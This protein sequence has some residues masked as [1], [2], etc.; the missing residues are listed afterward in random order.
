M[1]INALV[2]LLHG[3]TA[4]DAIGSWLD[5][6][7]CYFI[8]LPFP[9]NNSNQGPA[10]LPKEALVALSFNQ[11]DFIE[12]ENFPDKLP[13]W[14]NE[15]WWF[16]SFSYEAGLKVNEI[17][18]QNENN[19]NIPAV[20]CFSPD[21]VL[22]EFEKQWKVLYA[23]GSEIPDHVLHE[24]KRHFNNPLAPPVKS[25]INMLEKPDFASYKRAMSSVRHHL[26]RGDVYE[27]NYCISAQAEFSSLDAVRIFKKLA[28][29]T[30]APFSTLAKYDHLLLI[31]ASPE[32]FVKSDGEHIFLQPMKGTAKRYPENDQADDQSLKELL[33]SEKERAEN[34]MI[35][36][37]SRNDLAKLAGYGVSVTEL[38]GPRTLKNVHQMVSTIQAPVPQSFSWNRLMECLYPPG[39]MT[40]A[41]KVSAMK[42]INVLESFYRGFFSGITGYA[43]PG[44]KFDF[45][46]VIRSI[47]A[48]TRNRKMIIPAG[49]AIT[50]L[51]SDELEFRECMLKLEAMLLALYDHEN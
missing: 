47:I 37:L 46:V 20:A 6:M 44:G 35:V 50:L 3:K 38:F 29:R 13:Q 19:L 1:S 49:S 14:D 17:T 24:I 33:S 8:R 48:N 43:C 36:D 30:Y 2:S 25:S 10:G 32:R 42:T 45:C 18:P 16:A 11:P 22:S 31:S 27:L 39:S 51:S 34:V 12:L 41:P 5:L 7:P 28:L 23:A 4:L 15:G 9:E 21:I 26:Q 40:G